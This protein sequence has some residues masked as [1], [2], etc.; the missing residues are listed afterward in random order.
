MAFCLMKIVPVFASKRWG[1]D[2][3]STIVVEPLTGHK[4]SSSLLSC[5]GGKGNK[6]RLWKSLKA[7]ISIAN[8]WLLNVP[9]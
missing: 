1:G 9:N 2:V 5:A 7:G 8:R 3:C 6:L 4:R